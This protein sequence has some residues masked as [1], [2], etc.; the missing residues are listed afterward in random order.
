M[1]GRSLRTTPS[2]RRRKPRWKKRKSNLFFLVDCKSLYASPRLD[3][4]VGVMKVHHIRYL[5]SCVTEMCFL[6]LFWKI[7][8]SR[9]FSFKLVY[10]DQ[11][12][13][14]E[15]NKFSNKRSE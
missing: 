15:L 3:Y 14:R 2:L 6:F 7:L 12:A 9:T 1:C 10:I 4:R 13:L 8:S 11:V 5:H